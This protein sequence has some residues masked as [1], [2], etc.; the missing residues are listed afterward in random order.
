[1][2]K[3]KCALMIAIEYGNGARSD[4][5]KRMIGMYTARSRK[6]S[7]RTKQELPRGVTLILPYLGDPRETPQSYYYSKYE[8]PSTSL[9]RDV[10]SGFVCLG[11]QITRERNDRI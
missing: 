2:S 10:R 4:R 5:Y 6:R 11:G 9:L 8:V 7:L 3:V 1:M